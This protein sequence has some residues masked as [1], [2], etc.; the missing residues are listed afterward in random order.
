MG[1]E[2]E[3]L[4]HLPSAAGEIGVMRWIGQ[5]PYDGGRHTLDGGWIPGR[6]FPGM[7]GN[8]P[9]RNPTNG[10]SHRWQTGSPRFY[11]DQSKWLRPQTRDCQ[12]VR[13]T[14]QIGCLV[15][16]YPASEFRHHAQ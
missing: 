5:G 1:L 11:P 10:I 7:P 2:A 16:M 3:T 12:Q 6:D 15:A 9:I 8:Q 14:H 4:G 13:L